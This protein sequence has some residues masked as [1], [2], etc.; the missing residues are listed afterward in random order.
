MQ[1]IIQVQKEHVRATMELARDRALGDVDALLGQ[2]HAR[3][4]TCHFEK[5]PRPCFAVRRHPGLF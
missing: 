4:F 2:Q 1:A 5:S 3:E